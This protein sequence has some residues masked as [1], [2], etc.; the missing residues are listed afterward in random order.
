MDEELRVFRGA[1]GLSRELDLV[2]AEGGAVDLVG[3]L[4]VRRAFA[5]DRLQDDEG[6]FCLLGLGLFRER[7]D[8]LDVVG[9]AREDL[10]AVGF[11]AFSDVLG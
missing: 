1:E 2:G 4:F 10:P 8:S 9:V 5:D 11:E 6:G 7:E 3:A